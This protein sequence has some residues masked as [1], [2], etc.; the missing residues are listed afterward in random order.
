MKDDYEIAQMRAR[1]RR[2][3]RA[4]STTSWRTC[5]AIIE[6]PRG[7]RIVEG[8]FHQRARSDGNTVG[9]DTIAASGPHACYLHWTRNDGAV[10]PGDLIL[11]RRRRRG[12]QPLHR[13][14]HAHAS[15]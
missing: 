15:R 9:Y 13:R 3:P 5:P 2:S 12:R 10:V 4:A 6:H 7:E 14:H 1:R 8:V 11:D